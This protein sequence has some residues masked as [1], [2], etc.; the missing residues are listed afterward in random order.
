MSKQRAEWI[1]RSE[2]SKRRGVS[3]TA[4]TKACRGPLKAAC[5]GKRV[6]AAHPAVVEYLE[7]AVGIGTPAGAR[8]SVPPPPALPDRPRQ[9]IRRPSPDGPGSDADLEELAEVIG[10][11]LERFGTE[12]RFR[13]FLTAL[14][15]IEEIRAKRLANEETEGRLIERDL[16]RVHVFGAIDRCNRQLLQDSPKT[17]A[18]RLYGMAKA[19]APV[20]EAEKVVRDNLAS[21][22][23]PAKEHAARALRER[24][25]GS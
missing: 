12:L 21:Q 25:A 20:E 6:N 15:T 22:L 3:S 11:L 7:S 13:D 4:I 23:R 2:L 9:D 1:S 18:R 10:P 24:A 14:K 5:S 8:R 16:V 17:I 19:D